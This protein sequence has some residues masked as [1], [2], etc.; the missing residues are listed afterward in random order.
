MERTEEQKVARAPVIVILGGEEYSIRQLTLDESAVWKQQVAKLLSDGFRQMK[1]D[2]TEP[3][4]FS[5]ALLAFIIDSPNALIDLFFAYAKDL[6]RAEIEKIATETEIAVAWEK[7]R[8]VAFPLAQS[9]VE[10]MGK[11]LP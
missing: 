10:T 3:E 11:M 7:V 6:D 4:K 9:L 2:A 5:T 8:Q 1:T